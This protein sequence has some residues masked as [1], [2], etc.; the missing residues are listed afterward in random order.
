MKF[1]KEIDLLKKNQIEMLLEMKNPQSQIK[2]SLE[3][4][5]SRVNHREEAIRDRIQGRWI[6][7]VK[8]KDKLI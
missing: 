4:L 3:S 2:N 5:T 8:D 1:N 7:I 6:K